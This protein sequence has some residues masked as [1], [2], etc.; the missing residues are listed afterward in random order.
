MLIAITILAITVGGA[1]REAKQVELEAETWINAPAIVF[2]DNRSYVVLFFSTESDKEKREETEKLIEKLQKVA[3]RKDYLVILL[4][5]NKEAAVRRFIKKEKI[6]FPVGSGT[7]S[8]KQFKIEDYPKLIILERTADGKLAPWNDMPVNY[9]DSLVPG[10]TSSGLDSGAFDEGS[11]TET[12]TRYARED[13]SDDSREKALEILRGRMSIEAFLKLCGSLLAEANPATQTYGKIEYQ[14]QLADP[15]VTEKQPRYSP[16]AL[17]SKAR[18]ANPSD[19]CWAR[20]NEYEQ[21]VSGKP[22]NQLWTDYHASATDEPS[23]LLIRMSIVDDLANR[24]DKAGAR[25]LLMQMFPLETDFA[26]RLHVVGSMMDACGPG[27]TEAAD[28]LEAQLAHETNI[29]SVRPLMLATI[30]YLHTGE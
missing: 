14:R 30:H 16:C 4:S 23:D 13:P 11:P 22:L 20:V 25:S 9:L 21:A 8:N 1:E 10:E 27:D 2:P 28:F 18:R 5:P 26:V 12:L 24:T 6:E 7:K 29:R 3:K 19:V 15:S 17:A